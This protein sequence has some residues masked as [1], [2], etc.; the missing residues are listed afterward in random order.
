MKLVTKHLGEIEYEQSNIITFGD[1]L[2][3]FLEEKSFIIVLSGDDSFPFH[4][5]QSTTNPDI[6][7]IIT[8]PFLFVADYDFVVPD[9]VVSKL[10][11]EDLTDVS[12]YAITTIPDEVE[13]T[14]INCVAPIVVN[15]TMNVAMQ[16]ILQDRIDIKQLI[17]TQVKSQGVE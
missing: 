9:E 14:T 2:P 17:F 6:A 5:L 7:F 11:I 3:G 13:K 8:N 15:N 1:G 16:V 4:H 10:G 12:I